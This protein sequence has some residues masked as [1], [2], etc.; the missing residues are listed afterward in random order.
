M[1]P[2]CLPSE[3]NHLANEAELDVELQSEPFSAAYPE[4]Y[5]VLTTGQL[6]SGINGSDNSESSLPTD[7]ISIR[8]PLLDHL[9]FADRLSESPGKARL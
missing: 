8:D 9:T 6:F 5:T 2:K 3:C 7:D 4:R 1:A